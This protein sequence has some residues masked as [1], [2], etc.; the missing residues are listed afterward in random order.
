MA[1]DGAA[2]YPSERAKTIAGRFGGDFDE[3]AAAEVF[4]THLGAVGTDHMIECTERD[5]NRIFNLGYYTWVEQQ[6][7]P[8]D[9][10]EAR[11]AQSFWTG[12]RRFVPV[13]DELINEFN[14]RRAAPRDGRLPLRPLRGRGGR[15]RPVPVA[16]SQRHRRRPRL[17]CCASWMTG[18][19]GA[20]SPWRAAW[21]L[22][23]ADALVDEVDA[24]VAAVDGVGFHVTPFGRAD[25]LSDALGFAP[26]GGVW[27]KDETGNVAGSH[28][29]RHLARHPA[30]PAG[31]RTDGLDRSLATGRASPSPRAATPPSPPPR[32]PPPAAW[33]IDVFVPARRRPVGARPGC[34]ALGAAVVLS[35]RRAGRSRPAIRAS[36]ASATPSPPAPSPSACRARRTR[37]ASTSAARWRGRSPPAV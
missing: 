36:T 33:P 27:V 16:L 6:G 2:L 37:C 18:P 29:G 12:L 35:P 32:S 8:L 7:T 23:A 20:G 14:A 22:A 25:A 19:H 24:A 30:A 26:T 13:W 1:T 34:G 28:K 17:T 21:T 3:L 4:A 15:R 31:G 9:I 5:R 11:R 10:F